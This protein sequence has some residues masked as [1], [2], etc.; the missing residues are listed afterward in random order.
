[1]D[2]DYQSTDG[3]WY[4][5]GMENLNPNS[6]SPGEIIKGDTDLVI[7]PN[8]VY[9]FM[10]RW[11]AGQ[12]ILNIDENQ[13]RI[14]FSFGDYLC[15]NYIDTI[16]M[17]IIPMID[18]LAVFGQ[19]KEEGENAEVTVSGFSVNGLCPVPE[20]TVTEQFCCK[21]DFCDAEVCDSPVAPEP[22]RKHELCQHFYS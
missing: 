17:M 11:E 8:Q 9:Q 10:L 4:L 16:G 3:I 7:E 20:P 14:D 19:N 12:V 5:W 6:L 21:L 18:M 2:W 13:A 22:T 15:Q 1:M